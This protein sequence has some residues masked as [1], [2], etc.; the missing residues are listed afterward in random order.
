MQESTPS[1]ASRAALM[2]VGNMQLIM[3]IE[4]INRICKQNHD[5]ETLGHVVAHIGDL[6]EKV[7]VENRRAF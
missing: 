7:I 6:T 5:P 4:Q 2:Q 3:L 1:A